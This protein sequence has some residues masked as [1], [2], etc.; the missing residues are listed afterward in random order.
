[1]HA[2]CFDSNFLQLYQ[3]YFMDN[4]VGKSIIGRCYNFE[5]NTNG[6]ITVFINLHSSYFGGS[7]SLL[8]TEEN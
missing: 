1:M 2:R 4:P 7:Y 8:C 6:S 5:C 3:S